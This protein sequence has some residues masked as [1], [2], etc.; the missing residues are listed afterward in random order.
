MDKI[1]AEQIGCIMEIYVANILVKS[2]LSTNLVSDLEETFA[3]IQGYAMKL[4]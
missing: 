1:F 2:L 4:M 3:T